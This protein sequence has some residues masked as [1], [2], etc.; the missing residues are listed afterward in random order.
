MTGYSR[1]QVIGW[2]SCRG[3]QNL[4][5]TAVK[6]ALV[7][8][9]V[10]ALPPTLA[11]IVVAAGAVGGALAALPAG[12]L[13][14]RY[15][16]RALLQVALAI[17]AVLTVA[18]GVSC[19]VYPSFVL[20]T[21]LAVTLGAVNTIAN[22]AFSCLPV[23]VVPKETLSATMATGQGIGRVAGIVGAPLGAVA[24]VWTGQSFSGFGSLL[25]AH[26]AGVVLCF[27]GVTRWVRIRYPKSA[28]NRSIRHNITAGP[29]EVVAHQQVRRLV[30]C[31]VGSNVWVGPVTALGV[32]V[33]FTTA[34]VTT[35]WVGICQATLGFAA[36][37][38]TLAVGRVGAPRAAYGLI[39][40]AVQGLALIGIGF[41]KPWLSV[42]CMIVVG[43]TAGVASIS[44]G[45]E[46]VTITPS[47][48]LGRAI[49]LIQGIDMILTPLSFIVF[50][51]MAQA[52]GAHSATTLYGL[53][54]CAMFISSTATYVAGQKAS[55]P[56]SDAI[57]TPD[58]ASHTGNLA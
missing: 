15:N 56:N 9:T 29:M 13:A 49:A 38:A 31:L 28:S 17:E 22:T 45:R 51:W 43:L 3:V 35:V 19:I 58:E 33:A 50:G 39:T 14:D 24:S 26:A 23:Q 18:G 27:V 54:A 10:A 40:L 11:A 20:L 21:A 25:L 8:T 57:T 37:A 48:L 5:D 6:I 55:G 47:E 1:A 52:F 44:V 4:T 12:A 42:V 36:F 53:C 46:L 41:G 7:L 16:S 2:Q 34:G 30:V 32:A